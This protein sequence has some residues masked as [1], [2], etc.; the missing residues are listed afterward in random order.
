MIEIPGIIWDEDEDDGINWDEPRPSVTYNPNK[1]RGSSHPNRPYVPP[2]PPLPDYPQLRAGTGAVGTDIAQDAANIFLPERFSSSI[3]ESLVPGTTRRQDEKGNWIIQRDGQDFYMNEPGLGTQDALNVLGAVATGGVGAKTASSLPVAGPAAAGWLKAHPILSSGLGGGTYSLAQQVAGASLTDEEMSVAEIARD[4]AAAAVLPVAL[5]GLVTPFRKALA[6][7]ENTLTP[8]GELTKS[9]KKA[10]DAAGFKYQDLDPKDIVKINNA[11]AKSSKYADE[12]RGRKGALAA[13]DIEA[14]QGMFGQRP[15]RVRTETAAG[16][17]LPR[18]SEGA[19]KLGREGDQMAPRTDPAE[20]GTDLVQR[21]RAAEDVA[22]G[23]FDPARRAGDAAPLPP[24]IGEQVNRNMRKALGDDY[25][26]EQVDLMMS[27]FPQAK[28]GETITLLDHNGNPLKKV[29]LPTAEDPKTF[30]NLYEWRRDHLA[31]NA[32]SKNAVEAFDDE[33]TRLIDEQLAGEMGPDAIRAWKQANK[34]YSEFTNFWRAGDAFDKI[35]KKDKQGYALRLD[36]ENTWNLLFNAGKTGF[37][38]KPG[39][40]QVIRKMKT[41]LGEDSPAFDSFRAA[42][43]RRML[44]LDELVQPVTGRQGISNIEGHALNKHWN[45]V[46]RVWNGEDGEFLTELYGPKVMEKM[47]NFVLKATWLDQKTGNVKPLT[48][49]NSVI[50]NGLSKI[51]SATFRWMRTGAHQGEEMAR[52]YGTEMSETAL[53]GRLTRP[54]NL[55]PPFKGAGLAEM[56]E[57]MWDEVYDE[58]LRDSG[59]NISEYVPDWLTENAR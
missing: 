48:P 40:R 59:Y 27:K 41:V 55:V 4:T 10:L 51:R 6:H 5:R 2:E 7:L 38:S 8:A 17:T 30:R 31:P 1:P 43:Q 22:G 21:A 26:P 34:G 15:A 20:F 36:P 33:M 56:D 11:V 18:W 42:F 23:R 29:K 16:D 3:A 25:S 24:G 53:G 57:I 37:I 47:D 13:N 39:I 54:T 32:P 50:I 14:T 58:A 9:A 46:K 52:K 44:Q 45:R 12:V 28:P 49:S 35:I 19:D